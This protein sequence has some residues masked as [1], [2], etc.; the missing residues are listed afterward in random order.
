[1]AGRGNRTERE[2]PFRGW[3]LI[4]SLLHSTGSRIMLKRTS[5][6]WRCMQVDDICSIRNTVLYRQ[7]SPRDQ[8][9]TTHYHRLL[10]HSYYHCFINNNPVNTQ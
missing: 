3:R 2:T 8:V 1:M 10:H 4:V 7:E 9:H 6:S 5:Q